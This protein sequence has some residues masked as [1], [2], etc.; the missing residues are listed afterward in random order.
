[1]TDFNTTDKPV[2]VIGDIHGHLDRFE[3]LLKQEGLIDR[4]DNCGGG[5]EIWGPD[6]NEAPEYLSGDA[7]ISEE[8]K[9][10]DGFGIARVDEGANHIV[11]LGDIGHFGL[12]T[13][14]QADFM[15]Y[16]VADL[17]ADTILWG[18]HDRAVVQEEHA[19]RGYGPP[20]PE[21]KHL[22]QIL[23]HERKLKLAFA[24]HGFLFTHAGL[25]LSWRDTETAV[26]FD[27]D[28][29]VEIAAWLNVNDELWFNDRDYDMALWGVRDAIA[30]KRGGRAD[31]GGILWRDVNEKL[32]TWSPDHPE[33][34]RQ[35]FGHSADKEH[36]V[37][38]CGEQRFTR[39]L[40]P[41]DENPSY[42]IDVGGKGDNK[43]DDCLA[44]LWIDGSGGAWETR[45]DL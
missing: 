1:M 18:N 17:W 5:G 22:M 34:F 11:L 31:A 15:S 4:C 37:R 8:C 9:F 25:H 14:Q 44:G 36:A 21:T 12:L 26:S 43:G 2:L 42:C 19:F 33:R 30:H 24:A 32:Y 6:P 29:P 38:F 16:Q 23:R 20:L 7:A 45:V 10:C 35:V 28:D 40:D 41:R 13:S 27:H 3:A 39:K